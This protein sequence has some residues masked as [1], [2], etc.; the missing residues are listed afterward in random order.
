MF[1]NNTGFLPLSLLGRVNCK[2]HWMPEGTIPQLYSM[3]TKQ[4]C[5][6]EG[7]TGAFEGQFVVS[8][9]RILAHDWWIYQHLLVSFD[10][11]IRSC[12]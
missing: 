3:L 5:P 10:L 1:D 8:K 4:L 7:Y 12:L 11:H 9:K 2:D 6:P